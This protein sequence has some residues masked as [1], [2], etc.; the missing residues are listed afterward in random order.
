MRLILLSAI[1]LSLILQGT[2]AAAATAAQ[3][4]SKSAMIAAE[5]TFIADHPFIYFI[6]DT[7]DQSILFQG[8]FAAP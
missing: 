7:S 3:I 4:T 8:T 1:I 2:E 6:V 5:T